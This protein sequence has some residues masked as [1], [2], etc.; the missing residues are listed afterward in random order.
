MTAAAHLVPA[1]LIAVLADRFIFERCLGSEVLPGR[2][3][4]AAWAAKAGV[5]AGLLTLSS[6]FSWH[7]ASAALLPAAAD[8][9]VPVLVA[10]LIV[11]L[12][13]A[14][15]LLLSKRL[16]LTHAN[17][18]WQRAAGLASLIALIAVVPGVSLSGRFAL[19]LAQSTGRGALAGAAFALVSG[20]Y[21]GIREKEAAAAGGTRA[22][23]SF[24]RELLVA[25]LIAL[26]LGG[27]S[28]LHFLQ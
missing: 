16:G 17:R 24:A 19:S 27:I 4:L 10:G 6:F 14:G 15:E 2:S 5:V 23:A 28:G 25:G 13:I 7:I 26:A 9:C 12:S 8:Y 20:I 21:A 1:A 3:A 18:L 11:L 22:D